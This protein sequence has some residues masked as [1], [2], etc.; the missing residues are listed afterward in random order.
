VLIADDKLA[1]RE[2]YASYFAAHGIRVFMAGDGVNA[3]H[4]GDPL[5]MKST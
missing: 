1:E 2:M 3:G 4:V 5:A